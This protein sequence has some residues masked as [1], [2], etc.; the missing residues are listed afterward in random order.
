MRRARIALVLVPLLLSAALIATVLATYL[1]VRGVLATL[2]WGQ[3]DAILDS[4]AHHPAERLDVQFL[5]SI[6]EEQ[7]PE[8][9]RCIAAFDRLGRPVTVVGE[10]LAGDDHAALTRDLLEAR[11]HEVVE[12]EA[13]ERVR[14]SRGAPA[15]GKGWPASRDP[16]LVEF[17]PVMRR[18][19]EQ[20]ALRTLGIGGA[21]S[22]A[23]VAVALVLWR[24]S[25]REER[26]KAAG[27]RDRR[28]AALGEM[29][30][31]LAHEIRNPLASMKG[32]AQLLA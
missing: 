5:E 15:P 25:L 1:S 12:I 17:E 14:M 20:G 18:E 8:G 21:A 2:V 13:R 10:C 32:H 7:G 28:L 23:L 3:G 24:F 31:V 22:L 27:E 4:L 29:A 16:L 9:L 19:L 26:L 11:A 6:L 30:A